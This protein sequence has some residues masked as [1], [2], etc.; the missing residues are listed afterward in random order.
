MINKNELFP[1]I[2]KNNEQNLMSTENHNAE[3]YHAAQK[4][5]SESNLPNVHRPSTI[6]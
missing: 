1:G 2:M 5:K 4:R 3:K 6:P